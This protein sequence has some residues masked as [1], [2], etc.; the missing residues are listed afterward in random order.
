M[1][2]VSPV[3]AVTPGLPCPVLFIAARPRAGPTLLRVIFPP[4][5]QAHGFSLSHLAPPT[6]LPNSYY[7][8]GQT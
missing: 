5:K 2:P 1:K 6:P 3:P 4:W 7:L 8:L